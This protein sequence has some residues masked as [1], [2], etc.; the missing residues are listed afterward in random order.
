MKDKIDNLSHEY[1]S[2]IE[3]EIRLDVTMIKEDSKTGLDQT[4]HTEDD[5][6]MDK[7]TRVGQDMTPIIDVD[8]GTI[9]EVIKGMP[10]QIIIIIT[11]GET[12]GIRITIEIGVS[13]T[14]D[15]I[16][17]DRAVEALVTVGQA[18]VL[19]QLQIEIESDALSVGNLTNC[20]TRQASREAEQ[21]Q[22]MFN[23]DEDQT[24]LQTPLMDID[25][26]EQTVSP[27]ETRHTLNL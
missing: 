3:V 27:V 18:Q 7:I 26:D 12:L 16:E 22:Q 19:G 1:I 17:I 4:T 5:Q 8:I 9:Q 6:S 10:D 24:I 23:M 20:P 13:Y 14:R 15:K 2:L 25:Q 11:E 21:I